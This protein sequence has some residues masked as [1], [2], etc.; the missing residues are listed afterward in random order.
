MANFVLFIDDCGLFRFDFQWIFAL[1][2]WRFKMMVSTQRQKL[3]TKEWENYRNK[4]VINCQWWKKFYLIVPMVLETLAIAT[5]TSQSKRWNA[6]AHAIVESLRLLWTPNTE[7][8]TAQINEIHTQWA[9][10]NEL[11]SIFSKINSISWNAANVRM[12]W[13]A[14]SVCVYA[15]Y[16]RMRQP[17]APEFQWTREEIFDSSEHRMNAAH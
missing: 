4:I 10:S 8:Q 2:L 17:R 9:L 16:L 15:N 7:R 6:R 13:P 5:A 14:A 12:T 1:M 11:Y 3:R